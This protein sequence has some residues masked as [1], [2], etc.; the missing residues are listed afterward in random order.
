MA[1]ADDDDAIAIATLVLSVAAA[2]SDRQGADHWVQRVQP[3]IPYRP[4]SRRPRAR[5]C[6]AGNPAALARCP[7]RA[8]TAPPVTPNPDACVRSL[9]ALCLERAQV[10]FANT[11]HGPI[12][13]GAASIGLRDK[14][15][16][17][18]LSFRTDSSRQ[19][20]FTFRPA[21]I[22]VSDAVQLSVPRV[23]SSHDIFVRRPRNRGSPITMHNGANQT[24]TFA[25]GDHSGERP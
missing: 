14:T 9:K 1:N 16:R 22:I 7:A 18:S 8:A 13:I 17:F 15:Q 20:S 21:P 5:V 19:R 23:S 12:R 4:L 3:P 25:S 2:A 11:S 6:R 10:V 24:A